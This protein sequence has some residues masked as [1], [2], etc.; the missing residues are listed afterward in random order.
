[1]EGCPLAGSGALE[2]IGEARGAEVD[3]QVRV[4]LES[5]SADLDVVNEAWLYRHSSHYR[6]ASGYSTICWLVTTQEGKAAI[7]AV[8][9]SKCYEC[10]GRM[11]KKESSEDGGVQ[12]DGDGLEDENDADEGDDEEAADDDLA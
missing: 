5:V 2:T 3:I 7:D 12:Q 10:D 4:H 6:A 11:D 1:M 8:R 9:F